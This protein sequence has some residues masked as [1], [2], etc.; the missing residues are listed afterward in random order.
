MTLL[1]KY[2]GTKNKETLFQLMKMEMEEE[3][4]KSVTSVRQQEATAPFVE[5][6]EIPGRLKFTFSHADSFF[7]CSNIWILHSFESVKRLT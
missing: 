1:Q 2:K 3:R 5:D 6:H 4:K 7:R